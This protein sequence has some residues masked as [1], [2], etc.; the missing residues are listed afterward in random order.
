MILTADDG[1]SQ[2]TNLMLHVVSIVIVERKE[3][4]FQFYCHL[5]NIGVLNASGSSA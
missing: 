5:C 2:V 4:I 1:H 3:S